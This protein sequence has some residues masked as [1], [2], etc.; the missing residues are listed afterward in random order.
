MLNYLIGLERMIKFNKNMLAV[1]LRKKYR[2]FDAP[3]L[4]S[5]SKP[6]ESGTEFGCHDPMIMGANMSQ[7]NRMCQKTDESYI[8]TYIIQ[9][10]IHTINSYLQIRK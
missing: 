10:C 4:D 2:K 9:T 7:S 5:R 1:M 8:Q 6:N 3:T